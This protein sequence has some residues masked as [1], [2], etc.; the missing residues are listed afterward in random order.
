MNEH[1]S[2]ASCTILDVFTDLV[3]VHYG[4]V[5]VDKDMYDAS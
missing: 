3:A 4:I 1:I 5:F 2:L